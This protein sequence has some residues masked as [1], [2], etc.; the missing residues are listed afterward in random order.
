[1][2]GVRL[3]LALCMRPAAEGEEEGL[4]DE[5]GGRETVGVRKDRRRKMER[6]G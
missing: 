6:G 2:D 1:M 5:N 4:N 3:V